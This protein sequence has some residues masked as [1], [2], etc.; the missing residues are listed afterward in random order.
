MKFTRKKLII[1]IVAVLAVAAVAAY[2]WLPGTKAVAKQGLRA[3]KAAAAH[4]LPT[5]SVDASNIRQRHY[6]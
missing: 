2:L 3:T 1:P 5:E 4:Y 6:G